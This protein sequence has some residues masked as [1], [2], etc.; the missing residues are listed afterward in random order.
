MA[1]SRYAGGINIVSKC[2]QL[3]NLRLETLKEELT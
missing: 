3:Q 2:K 1:V